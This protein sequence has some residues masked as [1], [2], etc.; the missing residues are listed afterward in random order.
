MSFSILIYRL[1]IESK[2][3]ILFHHDQLT[4]V[5][6]TTIQGN[7]KALEHHSES[8]E[9]MLASFPGLHVVVP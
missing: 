9:G 8:I 2:V 3:Q 5:V 4:M 6:R 1:F 7:I